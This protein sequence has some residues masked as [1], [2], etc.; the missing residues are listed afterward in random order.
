MRPHKT[1][2]CRHICQFQRMWPPCW[3]TS[4]QLIWDCNLHFLRYSHQA[5][6][7]ASEDQQRGGS[8]QR[9]GARHQSTAVIQ[10]AGA[11]RDKPWSGCTESF[12]GSA[13][14]DH[15]STLHLGKLGTCFACSA[16]NTRCPIGPTSGHGCAV[17]LHRRGLPGQCCCCPVLH[18]VAAVT[19]GVHAIRVPM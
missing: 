6:A 13:A 14:V 1:W 15:G 9:W 3:C 18:E 11:S 19:A 8:G 12:S 4:I 7:S 17:R 10:A 5:C 16:G 2:V